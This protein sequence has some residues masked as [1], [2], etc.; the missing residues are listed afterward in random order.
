MSVREIPALILCTLFFFLSGSM[1]SLAQES[2][3]AGSLFRISIPEVSL[4]GYT[5]DASG[6][7]GDNASPSGQTVLQP[8]TDNNNKK[9]W[10]H[11]SAITAKESYNIIT[12]HLSSGNIPEGSVLK[13]IAGEDSGKGQGRLGSIPGVINLSAQPQPIIVNIGSCHTGKGQGCGHPLE[14]VWEIP[15]PSTSSDPIN[16]TVT[17]TMV[18]GD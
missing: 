14:Y 15:P 2:N 18:S 16:I 11:Y 8:V 17:Y 4:V 12:A 1:L 6:Y 5:Y 7:P 9:I 3:T 10:L 13:V